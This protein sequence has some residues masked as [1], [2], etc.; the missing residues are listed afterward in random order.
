MRL[1]EMRWGD[2]EAVAELEQE[3][4]AGDPPWSAEQFWSELAG[5]PDSRWYVVAVSAGDGPETDPAIV[6]Y[7]GLLG[8][9]I[10]GEPADVM[11][12]AVASGG[13]RRGTGT[14][15]MEAMIAEARRRDAGDLLL[16]V[17]TD[18]DAARAFYERHGFERL[19]IRRNYYGGNRDG[20]VMRRRLPRQGDN[21][22]RD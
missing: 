11:T 1:R 9:A 4:F 17:R 7:A 10:A 12:I 18:N 6:G 13:Q 16:E 2:V 3:L 20:I 14:V 5:V 21:R 19:A 15:L 8:P 22:H